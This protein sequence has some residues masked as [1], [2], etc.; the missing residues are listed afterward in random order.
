VIHGENKA[1]LQ[2]KR[3]HSVYPGED[4]VV[5]YF[6]PEIKEELTCL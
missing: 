1:L 3:V 4:R 5:G 2:D 6:K